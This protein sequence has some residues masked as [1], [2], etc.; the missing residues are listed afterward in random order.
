MEKRGFYKGKP[1]IGLVEKTTVFGKRKQ[2]KTLKAR[3]DTGATKSSIDKGLAEKLELG[4][5]I[6][7]KLI[8]SA[9]G[10]AFR[11]IIR[12]KIRLATKETRSKFTIADRTHMRYKIL[13]GRNIL[14]K[15]FLIDPAK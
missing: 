14:R 1:I 3:I 9:H 12:V 10:N 13:I 6:E 2:K 7:K 15:H 8:K 4:P 11:P 5:V